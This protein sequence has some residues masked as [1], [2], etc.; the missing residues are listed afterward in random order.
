MTTSPKCRVSSV[1]S[2]STA[3]SNIRFILISRMDLTHFPLSHW[4]MSTTEP[5]F[6]WYV[7]T[8]TWPLLLTATLVDDTNLGM[9]TSL[10]WRTISFS[11]LMKRTVGVS[12]TCV[13]LCVSVEI[14]IY[15]TWACVTWVSGVAHVCVG[16]CK[17]VC[18]PT[19]QIQSHNQISD[20][21]NGHTTIHARYCAQ[22]LEWWKF[23][24]RLLWRF[25]GRFRRA[26]GKHFDAITSVIASYK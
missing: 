13:S 8:N 9:C 26:G 20:R 3:I 21:I 4:K 25:L 22:A 19:L 18:A 7:L 1:P 12:V 15:V 16:V 11:G 6:P 5:L 23:W 24:G 2:S 10:I 17:W 14:W